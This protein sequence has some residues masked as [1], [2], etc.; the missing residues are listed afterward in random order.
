M[1]PEV[2]TP[3]PPEEAIRREA[4]ELEAAL[5]DGARLCLFG[6]RVA[7]FD[8]DP[9]G[10]VRWLS[11][12][13]H[14]TLKR[15]PVWQRLELAERTLPVTAASARQCLRIIA[16]GRLRSRRASRH[17][18]LLAS[19]D[20]LMRAAIDA[21][22]DGDELLLVSAPTKIRLSGASAVLGA[23]RCRAEL[24]STHRRTLL[25]GV[26][27]AGDVVVEA[28]PSPIAADGTA[29]VAST[30]RIELPEPLRE[31][32][33]SLVLD[34]PVERALEAARV[35]HTHAVNPTE[36]RVVV[37]SLAEAGGTV[38]GWVRWFLDLQDDSATEFRETEGLNKR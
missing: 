33:D 11:A 4:A 15:G 26:S 23:F 22:L 12:D 32:R 25:L 8:A 2:D 14:V 5:P 21:V 10:P 17:P 7:L 9:S 34:D 1:P 37:Q 36:A 6:H 3:A 16:L 38:A 19:S 28:L 18:G 35:A 29:I 31:F 27:P 24:L 20:A 13:A 30:R